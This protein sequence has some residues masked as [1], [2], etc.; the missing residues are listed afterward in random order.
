M[1]KK[2]SIRTCIACNT[3]SDKRSLVRFVR[4]PE[5]DIAFDASGKSAGRG[6][7]ICA[8]KECFDKARAKHLLDGRL[9]TKVGNEE[10]E[11]LEAEFSAFVHEHQEQR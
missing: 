11:R 5:G 6:A 3:S 4:T 7:Y 8:D 10:Y 1:A 2:A 9:R